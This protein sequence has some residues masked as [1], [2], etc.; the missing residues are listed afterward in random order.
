[1][2]VKFN[3][4]LHPPGGWVFVDAQEVKHRGASKAQLIARVINYRVIN[5]L[6]VGDPAEEVNAQLCRNFPG[7]CRSTQTSRPKRV[8]PQQNVGCTSCGKKR[9]TR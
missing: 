2:S 8:M 9:K 1:M 4:G 7:Y 5:H 6:A 3:P